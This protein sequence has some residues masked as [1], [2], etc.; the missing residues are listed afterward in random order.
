MSYN[1][2]ALGSTVFFDYAGR[3]GWA[4]FR[5]LADKKAPAGPWRHEGTSTDPAQWAAWIKE[6]YM[7]GVSACASRVILIDV[8][9]GK[10]GR[11]QA[12]QWF[13]AWCRSL[14]FEPPKPY[15]QSRSG[16][17]H[18]AFCCPVDFTPE[19]HRGWVSIKISHFRSLANGEE[20]GEVIS[21]RNRAYCVA[22]GAAYQGGEY[23]FYPD[24]PDPAPLPAGLHDLLKRKA[25]EVAASGRSGLSELTDVAALYAALDQL[26]A[27]D[28]EPD[29]FKHV[30]AIKLALGDTEEAKEVAREMTNPAGKRWDRFGSTWA[31]AKT[32]DPGDDTV[33]RIGTAIALYKE[34]TGNSFYVRKSTRGMFMATLQAAPPTAPT[35]PPPQTSLTSER[36]AWHHDC[37][38]DNNGK[39]L[40]VV[41]SA[42]VAI[43]GEP[44][45]AN[46]IAFDEMMRTTMLVSS[47]G[48]AGVFPRPLTDNDVVKVQRWM[49]IAGIKRV[50]K[51]VVHDAVR[52]CADERSYHPL[53]DYLNGLQWDRIPRLNSW[54]SKYLGAEAT[55]YEAAIGRMFPIAM[56]ARIFRPGCQCDYMLVLEGTQGAMKSSACK[57]LGGPW[58]SDALPDITSK[59]AQQHLR[60]K[61][62]IEV[63]EMHAMN[64]AETTLLKSFI[65]RTE[66]K[67]R[68]SHGRL[69]VVEPRQCIF[70]GTTNQTTYLRDETGGRRFWPVKCGR[71][72]IAALARD[73]DQLFAEAVALYKAGEPWWPNKDFEREHIAPQQAAR[74]EADV[75]EDS[76]A[77][78]VADKVDVT[79]SE[80]AFN[81]LGKIVGSIGTAEQRRIGA[82]LS[83]L[84]WERGKRTTGGKRPWVR[85]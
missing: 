81:A 65:T 10:V 77:R 72:D 68:P 26:G 7:L 75:W 21:V 84:G 51:D 19:A 34:L 64:R 61:W 3:N 53:R 67:Y 47:I 69:E 13:A 78:Y 36:P 79:I 41:A 46:A 4:L 45:I 5:M 15:G 23:L 38:T 57:V 30:G 25:V 37:L 39:I 14:G 27:F 49:Q 76:I 80:V 42:V 8:D 20:D 58:F 24:A 63:A 28:A 18:F 43:Q 62:L 29:W 56:V 60:G 50:G 85:H 44:R 66:E 54:L 12:F 31:R 59:D 82:A 70:I 9:V 2:A 48:D 33:C 6:G 22:P 71:I 52:L 35:L 40:P 83:N 17:W 11:E 16:G 74:Y 73:R 55:P 1:E 32:N